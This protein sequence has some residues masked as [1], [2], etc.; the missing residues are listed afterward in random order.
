M[1]ENNTKKIYNNPQWDEAIE[2][3]KAVALLTPLETKIKW[4]TEVYCYNN[5][6]VVAFGGFKNHFSVWFYNGVFLK[7]THQVL[8]RSSE[9]TKALRQWKFTSKDAIDEKILLDYILEAIE[10]AKQDLKITETPIVLAP[11]EYLQKFL[12]QDTLL[13]SNFEALSNYKK[14]EYIEFIQEA[15]QEKT[16]YSRLEKIKPMILSNIGLHDKYR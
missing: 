3:L 5:K 2:K 9:K 15:K 10:I 16:K 7:D 12:D 4:G 8:E 6:N 1:P 11:C 13:K 14:K